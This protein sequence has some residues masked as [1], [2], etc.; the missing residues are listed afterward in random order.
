MV[1]CAIR[2]LKEQ[3]VHRHR[4]E[5][6]QHVSRAISDWH[7]RTTIGAHTRRRI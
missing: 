7:A 1:E 3:R 4:F 6:L 5:S 2:T